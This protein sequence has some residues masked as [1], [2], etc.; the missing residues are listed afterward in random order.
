MLFW[1]IGSAHPTA[2]VDKRFFL[3][4]FAAL[5]C[6][7]VLSTLYIIFLKVP[8]FQVGTFSQS[9][10]RFNTYVGMAIILTAMGET[11]VQ[12]FG[13]LIGMVIPA[14]NILAVTILIWYSGAVYTA[15]Q[16]ILITLKALGS[17][18]LILAC[19]AGYWFSKTG[20]SFPVFISNT[21]Q[22]ASWATLPLALLSIGGALDFKTLKGYLRLAAVGSVFK[23]CLLPLIGYGF[24]ILFKVNHEPF[25]VAMIFFTLPASSAIYVL[26]SQLNSD[27][28]LASASIVLSTILS[29]FT[30]SA[31]LLI[32]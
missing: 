15:R 8:D 14:I 20:L 30:L 28:Q 19:L 29:F 1:K 4:V 11:G 25:K 18:P 6:I 23:L 9:C 10:Y 27:T 32:D 31:A 22:L 16:R 17:N 26:S 24:L 3:A 12:Y 13:I 5:L 21:F 2:L 7:F